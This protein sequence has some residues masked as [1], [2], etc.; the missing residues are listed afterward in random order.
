MLSSQSSFKAI[1]CHKNG[2]ALIAHELDGGWFRIG[3]L[4]LILRVSCVGKNTQTHTQEQED[5][6][7]VLSICKE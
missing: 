7:T 3:F 5:R 6:H 2:L 1:F 4:L